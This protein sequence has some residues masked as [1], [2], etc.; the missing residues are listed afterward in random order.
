MTAQHPTH[1]LLCDESGNT[2]HDYMNTDQPVFVYAGLLLETQKL[3]ELRAAIGEVDRHYPGAAEKKGTALMKDTKGRK[4][5]AHFIRSAFALGGTPIYSVIEKKFSVSSRMVETLF[6]PRINPASRLHPNDDINRKQLALVL[7]DLPDY[8]LNLFVDA[9]HNPTE[10][11]FRKS[12]T[13]LIVAMKSRHQ[14]HVAKVLKAQ[15]EALP[16]LVTSELGDNEIWD[17]RRSKGL[18]INVGALFSFLQMANTVA[19]SIGNPPTEVLHHHMRSL[20]SAL[21]VVWHWAKTE[22]PS[23][24]FRDGRK[25]H[26]GLPALKSMRFVE[27]D[28][29]KAI[30]AADFLA[31]A[32]R[33]L[34]ELCVRRKPW[35]PEFNELGALVGPTLQ[36]EDTSHSQVSPS[37]SQQFADSLSRCA[38]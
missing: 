8:Y 21:Q 34:V 31:A 17:K 28:A 1:V 9:F 18:S 4:A 14:N 16:E 24:V 19:Q 15:L 38:Q 11:A 37:T 33:W 22:Q 26:Y 3:P 36:A 27:A 35:T 23:R 25:I 29:E 32:S 7:S 5:L 20:E 6:D 13:S 10:A 30:R 12:I 2:G